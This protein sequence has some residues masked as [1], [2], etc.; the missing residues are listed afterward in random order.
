MVETNQNT[1]RDHAPTFNEIFEAVT[2]LHPL[3][4]IALARFLVLEFWDGLP[5]YVREEVDQTRL[6]LHFCAISRERKSVLRH[7]KKSDAE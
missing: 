7:F 3:P 6:R 4:I 1:D 2:P 5:D